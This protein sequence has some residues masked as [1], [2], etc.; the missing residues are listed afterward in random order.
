MCVCVC[1]CVSF[2][3]YFILIVISKHIYDCVIWIVN[4]Y[5]Y[6]MFSVVCV[7]YEWMEGCTVHK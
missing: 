1:V 7:L 6:E 3:E 2:S 4:D 5:D